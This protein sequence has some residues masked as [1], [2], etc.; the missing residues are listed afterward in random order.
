MSCLHIRSAG[1]AAHAAISVTR[2]PKDHQPHRFHG[3]L[4]GHHSAR[5]CRPRPASSKLTHETPPCPACHVQPGRPP[6]PARPELRHPPTMAHGNAS[7]ICCRRVKRSRGHLAGPRHEQKVT[8]RREE[9]PG[10]LTRRVRGRQLSTTGLRHHPLTSVPSHGWCLLAA[11]SRGLGGPQ[12]IRS[13][14]A[15]SCSAWPT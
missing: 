12:L 6:R 7:A 14:A 8:C 11:P 15:S 10:A 4:R 2:L 1:S 13:I 9:Q 3:S 5:L